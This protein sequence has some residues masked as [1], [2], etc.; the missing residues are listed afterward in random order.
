MSGW[1]DEGSG[2][3]AVLRR[4]RR[5]LDRRRLAAT[6]LLR[7]FARAYP[8]A[9]FVQIGANDGTTDDA[10]APFI[11]SSAWTGILVEPLPGA[12]ERLRA[13][14]ASR[15]DRL[16]L[17]NAAISDHDGAVSIHYPC[18]VRG[19]EVVDRLETLASLSPE[20]A[21]A[22][23]AD[24]IPDAEREIVREDVRAMSLAT[25]LREQGVGDLDLLAI[26]AEGY[27]HEVLAQVDFG[28]LRPRLVVYEHLLLDPADRERCRELVEA[29]GYETLAEQKDTWCLEPRDDE[30][31]RRFRS[32]TPAVAPQSIHDDR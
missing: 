9:R 30:L 11:A 3:L 29:A 26:D 21:E 1:G 4:G 22:T 8:E 25:L 18:R 28:A 17:V 7:A 24:F 23:G 6:R 5:A 32:M 16:A 14:H 10:L 12:F 31:T 15:A 2:P 13:T 19:G 27:D 20:L